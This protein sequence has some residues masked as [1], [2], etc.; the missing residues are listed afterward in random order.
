MEER[1]EQFQRLGTVA[2]IQAGRSAILKT[3]EGHVSALGAQ[4]KEI[5]EVN[6]SSGKEKL[7]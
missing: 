3:Q 6:D 4:E 7:N 2:E 1:G 5:A